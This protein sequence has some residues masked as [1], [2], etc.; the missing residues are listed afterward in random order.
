MFHD[1]GPDSLVVFNGQVSTDG[2]FF[3]N[4][5]QVALGGGTGVP[6]IGCNTGQEFVYVAPGGRATIMGTEPGQQRVDLRERQHDRWP[7]HHGGIKRDLFRFQRE[8]PDFG[9]TG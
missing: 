3:F 7:E 9:A 2:G 6:L 4:D 5:G 1:A 8:L